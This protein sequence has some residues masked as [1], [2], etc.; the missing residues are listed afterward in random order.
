MIPLVEHS[1][2]HWITD[3]MSDITAK[4]ALLLGVIPLQ[5]NIE[6]N[7]YTGTL[8]APVSSMKAFN[9]YNDKPDYQPMVADL[10]G[11]LTP[12]DEDKTY[13]VQIIWSDWDNVLS[14]IMRKI[15][16][17]EKYK[18]VSA[19]NLVKD[20]IYNN[21]VKF[22]CTCPSFHWQGMRYQL[23][24]IDSAIYPIGIKPGMGLK[25]P[26]FNWIDTHEIAGGTRYP[27]CKH[28]KAVLSELSGSSSYIYKKILRELDDNLSDL[29]LTRVRS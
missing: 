8:Y 2:I 29:M 26:N 1:I 3:K 14:D 13:T 12:K 10:K 5:R 28:I 18:G 4:R 23:S 7:P 20:A 25:K 27:L 6:F 19:P 24:T 9:L 22:H 16:D 15:N 17:R 11:K 21:D